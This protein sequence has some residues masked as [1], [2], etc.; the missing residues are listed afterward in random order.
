[1]RK[2]LLH[3]A[4]FFGLLGLAACSA[5]GTGGTSFSSTPTQGPNGLN[6]YV[7]TADIK[8]ATPALY[9]LSGSDGKVLWN[10][11][12]QV[13]LSGAPVLDHGIAFVGTDMGLGAINT[14]DGKLLWHYSTATSVRVL[15]VVNGVVYGDSY[16]DS[17]ANNSSVFA[18][19]AS[20]GSVRW[21]Y[22][23]TDAVVNGELVADGLVYA[24]AVSKE[25]CHCS[26]KPGYHVA[27]NASDG[28]VRWQTPQ[29]TDIYN[30]Q[31]V[32][33]GL[34][35]GLD[36]MTD[37]F[38]STLQARKASDGS[39]AWQYPKASESA[40]LSIIGMD[41][42]A[43]YV[44]SNDGDFSNFPNGGPNV[45][46]ALNASDG[47]VLWRSQIADTT[48]TIPTLIDQAIYLSSQDGVV[49]A[50]NAADGKLLWHAQV[51]QAGGS[52]GS[53]TTI[54]AVVNGVVYLAFPQGFAALGASD[55]S[56]KWQYQASG[57]TA[58]SAVANGVVYASATDA[59]L[60]AAGNNKIYALNASDGVL[61]WGYNAPAPFFTPTV[62]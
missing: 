33:N 39:I 6:V 50:L 40:W 34:V 53:G 41:S 20:D 36:G 8:G 62:G 31:L 7:S 24:E 56:I 11:V 9:A 54:A 10:Y 2:R 48:S 58:I 45:V 27:L 28:S 22:Q 13:G 14:R 12:S 57:E 4:L 21:K 15:S 5:N 26:G 1:M 46:Y 59:S 52:T 43:I 30:E 18:L 29:A 17:D 19:N 16:S 23:P 47:S 3:M 60:P 37:E 25:G 61:L 44:L 42:N 32:G 38:V 35:Y 49:T 55:G 51:G